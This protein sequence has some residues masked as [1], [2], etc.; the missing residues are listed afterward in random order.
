MLETL[1]LAPAWAL[2]GRKRV[3]R[4]LAEFLANPNSDSVHTL[5]TEL[6][7]FR[8]Q[9]IVSQRAPSLEAPQ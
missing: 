5:Q 8:L 2:R 9:T 6:L 3:Q 1:D 7:R 4:A